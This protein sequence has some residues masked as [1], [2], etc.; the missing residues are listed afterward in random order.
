MQNKSDLKIKYV[1]NYRDFEKWAH[2]IQQGL[3]SFI[4]KNTEGESTEANF[5]E[6]GLLRK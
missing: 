1:E 5:V 2:V 6:V 3:Q 4:L